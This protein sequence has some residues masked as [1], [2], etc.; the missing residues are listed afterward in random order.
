M[1]LPGRRKDCCAVAL[2]RATRQQSCGRWGAGCHVIRFTSTGLARQSPQPHETRYPLPEKKNKRGGE[3]PHRAPFEMAAADFRRARTLRFGRFAAAVSRLLRVSTDAANGS[4]TTKVNWS[5][6]SGQT[7]LAASGTAVA[8]T[9]APFVNGCSARPVPRRQ[10]EPKR[11]EHRPH[12]ADGNSSTGYLPRR[13]PPVHAFT[14][15]AVSP[16]ARSASTF[17]GLCQGFPVAAEPQLVGLHK[18]RPAAVRRS[19]LVTA[20]A[21]RTF[22]AASAPSETVAA[23]VVRNGVCLEPATTAPFSLDEGPDITA[24]TVDTGSAVAGFASEAGSP[25]IT[26]IGSISDLGLGGYTPAGLV[27]QVVEA[28]H[29]YSGLP[30]WATIAATTLA[31]RLAL[32]PVQ[33]SALRNTVRQ[34]NIQPEYQ[35]LATKLRKSIKEKQREDT[36]RYKAELKALL[37]EN[38]ITPA[39][40]F[41]LPFVQAPVLLSLFFAFRHFSSFPIPDITQG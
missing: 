10:H 27:E 15:R 9:A 4:G 24:E 23:E 31:F 32:F 39:K 37:K 11:S 40:G 17:H 28:V 22:A 34:S 5:R 7:R 33:L 8:R 25:V 13:T 20:V 38:N 14:A 1:N 35:E 41:L 29:V 12:P 19:V 18:R 21:N 2:W 36:D 3:T 16:Q 26:E 30:F 6:A